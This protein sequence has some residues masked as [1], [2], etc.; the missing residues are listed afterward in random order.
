MAS[1]LVTLIVIF[2]DPFG[3]GSA[4]ERYSRQVFYQL[5]A[6]YYPQSG[7]SNT[8]VVLAT[9]ETVKALGGEWPIN[10]RAHALILEAILEERPSAVMVDV[11]FLDRREGLEDLKDV[12]RQNGESNPVPVYIAA[13][14]RGLE[15]EASALADLDKE[16][17]R[18]VSVESADFY[19]DTQTYPAAIEKRDGHMLPSAAFAIASDLCQL[20]NA[21]P[22]CA[23]DL[24]ATT[25]AKDVEIVWGVV[26][27]NY[28]EIE[29]AS[30]SEDYQYIYTCTD[31]GNALIRFLTIFWHGRDRLR[32]TCYYT[33]T[34]EG[35]HLY[36]TINKTFNKN[37]IKDRIVFYGLSVTGIED[38]TLPPT[39]YLTPG[40]YTHAMAIDNI[41]VFGKSYISA[42]NANQMIIESAL[43]LIFAIIMYVRK[44]FASEQHPLRSAA[45]EILF[46]SILLFLATMASCFAFFFLRIPP[47]NWLAVGSIPITITI[48]GALGSRPSLRKLKP[49]KAP[50]KHSDHH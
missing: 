39:H 5:Y 3:M 14:P 17:I 37:I 33:P 20:G 21:A 38:F 47:M 44:V 19:H 31:Y 43:A 41:I 48:A 45:Y 7:Q 4:T 8:S 18:F 30:G 13:P 32:Q 35:H 12:L 28:A 36:N 24:D 6:P 2:V 16:L 22:W 9:D 11:L 40:V 27:P 1:L 34:I 49:R 23:F 26:P 25:L 46:A 42:Q 10:Y 50:R 29:G 15:L